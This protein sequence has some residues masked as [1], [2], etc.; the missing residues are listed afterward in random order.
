MLVNGYHQWNRVAD[1]KTHVL[2]MTREEKEE[3]PTK[4][5]AKT[6]KAGNVHIFTPD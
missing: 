2:N 6:V 3:E 5:I 1:N 4:L